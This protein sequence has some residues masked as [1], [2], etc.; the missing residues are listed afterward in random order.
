M[1]S[2]LRTLWSRSWAAVRRDR[3]D[4]EFDEELTTHLE[5]LIDEGRRAGLSYADARR[6]AL[7]RLGRPDTLRELHRE[8]RGL[9]M[10]DLLA[11]DLRYSLRALRKSPAFA[12]VVV[13]SLAVGIG[14]NTALFSLVDSLLLRSLP[15]REPDRLVQVRLFM[16]GLGIRKPFDGF[17]KVAF[18]AVGADNEVF[19]EIVGFG[20]LDRP[21][22]VIDGTAEAS[23]QVEHVSPNYFR[24]L[25]ITP[26]A[27]RAPDSSDDGVA[28]VSYAWWR[29]RFDGNQNVLGRSLTIDGQ[30]YT[31]IGVAPQRFAG[32]SIDT[33]T[34][35]WI[36]SRRPS[37]QQMVARLKPGVSP[38]H[39]QAAVY[40]RFRQLNQEQPRTLPWDDK[41]EVELPPAGKGLSQ[42]R[43]QYEG[44]LLA[45]TALV[46]IVLLIT[47]TNVGNLLM[48]RNTSRRREV[49]VR[50]ALGAGRSRLMMQYLVESAVLAVLGGVLGI[51]F[52][53]W[54]VSII[55][56]M[57]PLPAVPDGLA[58]YA[59]TRILLFVAGVSL[60]SA[61]LFGLAPAWR[62]ATVDL[63]STLRSIQ[64][65]A[66][67]KG[68]RRL[69]R[70][71]VACQI[72]LSLLL[73][74]GAGLFVQTLR[75]LAT[76]DVGFN[77]D[78]LLQVS[79]DTRGSG[80]GRSQVG[81]LYHLLLERVGAV[82]GVQSVTG[83][84]NP[85]MQGGLSRSRMLLPGRELQP[86]ES[87][88][89]VEVGPG[90][91]ETMGMRALR[92]RTFTAADFAGER[93]FLAI[94]E[95]FANHYFPGADPTG[96]H[97]GDLEIVGVVP[98][99]KFVSVRAPKGPLM[100]FMAPAEPD[101]FNSL[102]VRVAGAPSAIAPAIAQAV[103]QVNPRLLIG[104]RPMRE[105][106]NR[107]MAKE[108]MVAAI[109]GF[110][111]LLGV[112]LASIGLFG[113]ASYSVAQRTSE[114][115]IR[116]ALG[117]GHWSVIREAL[118]DTMR[119]FA[120]GL[121]AGLIA[122]IILVRLTTRFIADLLFGLT[123]TDVATLMIAA[124]VLILVGLLACILPARR[125][126]RIDVLSA[127]RET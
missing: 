24:D 60:L 87:W 69:G 2:W 97:S 37:V 94:S 93:R 17:P 88:D 15:V 123:A 100:Y 70:W 50:I 36:S 40:A 64:S 95:S 124:F 120:A 34:D 23:R 38:A 16:P 3:L 103:Q 127:I 52:A 49:T 82:P 98:D 119:V 47:C 33:T 5:L 76:L 68:G 27:G 67:S 63:A 105:E 7:G 12:A 41:L 108:R 104:I 92:G 62:G 114:L 48:L 118:R 65:T 121:A 35:L 90:F 54:G 56:A 84:R 28:I 73:L 111:S 110:F 58:F 80:Y 39:A 75:N 29:A 8:Q 45:L 117:A 31:I 99:A 30:A 106:L 102:V 13:L 96:L 126:T 32:L 86:D 44:P 79:I 107:S 55:L 112:V 21:A 14:A 125:A 20:R 9:P 1:M 83:I 115:G 59:D 4:R 122:A 42:L 91:F 116:L 74:V 10:L 53:A 6:Q 43:T 25:G 109:S 11:Q 51:A 89:A 18:E 26:V 101:R 71:L 19:S 72:G 81:P 77:P 85:I 113:V 46:T 61:L 22:I 66:P 57:L 78:P